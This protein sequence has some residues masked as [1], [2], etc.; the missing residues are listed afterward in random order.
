VSFANLYN[1]P[2]PP[3]RPCPG[4]GSRHHHHWACFEKVSGHRFGRTDQERV[5]L[6]AHGWGAVLEFPAL[7]CARCGVHVSDYMGRL[8]ELSATKCPG[9]HAEPWWLRA[10]RWLAS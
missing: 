10:L 9:P 6:L 4:C 8:T 2:P 3:A 1:A 5:R 7:A